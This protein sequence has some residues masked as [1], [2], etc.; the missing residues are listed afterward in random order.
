MRT[1]IRARLMVLMLIPAISLTALSALQFRESLSL[2]TETAQFATLVE[3][4]EAQGSLTHALQIERTRTLE[5]FHLGDDGGMD[6][7]GEDLGAARAATDQAL[8]AFRA[9]ADPGFLADLDPGVA[10]AIA[11][12]TEAVADVQESRAVIDAGN[13]MDGNVRT[14]YAEPI[15]R[16][17]SIDDTVVRIATNPVV[18]TR[19]LAGSSFARLKDAALDR[20]DV[21][22]LAVAGSIDS[23]TTNR[24]V[25]TLAN[26]Q[27]LWL[28]N[29]R[30]LLPESE[31]AAYAEV[32]AVSPSS[33]VARVVGGLANDALGT[34]EEI[35][36]DNRAA[37]EALR[38][39]EQAL[40]AESVRQATAVSDA[41]RQDAIVYGVLALL[42]VLFTVYLLITLARQ[43]TTPMRRLTQM[44]NR[45]A[46]Q[47]PGTVEAVARGEEVDNDVLADSAGA[48]LLNRRDELGDLARALGSAT[49]QASTLALEQARTRQGVARTI[50]DV[51]R[52]E[53]SL[54]ERQLSLLE[55]MEEAEEDPEQLS[56]LFRLD[57][58]ATRMRRNAENLLLLS[59]GQLPGAN[60]TEPQPLVDVIRTAAAET[61]E[62]ARVDVRVGMSL[63][64]VGYAATPISHLLAEL[65]ENATSFSPPTTRVTVTSSRDEG[66]VVVT[67]T[68]RGLGMEAA[69]LEEARHRL[70]APPML[71]AAE[72]RRLGLYVVGLLAKRLGIAVDIQPRAD[73]GLDV[74]VWV[75]AQ[76]FT[77]PLEE[78]TGPA[79]LAAAVQQG[80][81]PSYQDETAPTY[82]TAA[83][84]APANG[85]EAPAN[86][87]FGGGP[88]VFDH[89]SAPVMPEMPAAPTTPTAPATPAAPAAPVAPH[90]ATPSI[91]AAPDALSVMHRLLDANPATP[92]PLPAD[93][94]ASL[95]QLPN[96][97]PALPQ[98][99]AGGEEGRQGGL[100]MASASGGRTVELQ[101]DSMASLVSGLAGLYGDDDAQGPTPA[102]DPVQ[103]S[104]EA[105]SAS[106]VTTPDP[107][108]PV[109]GYGHQPANPEAPATPTPQPVAPPTHLGGSSWSTPF[110]SREEQ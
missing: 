12:A 50:S 64:I 52:R 72:S 51:A 69:D 81:Q 74:R 34:V 57:H 27:D 71:E 22:L 45:V 78:R 39:Q 5:A 1:S 102:A 26:A 60:E 88:A 24:Q 82:P 49:D 7:T 15:T 46:E 54:V 91:D 101:A 84:N 79:G 80:G 95:P 70:T 10:E 41:A 33:E 96:R 42:A 93:V 44:A 85:V 20:G 43:I 110:P 30:R 2:G 18:Q 17:L 98:R 83:P 97:A 47:L 21:V 55:R 29:L 59:A 11:A 63:D 56:Q 90:A 104:P 61:E 75:P 4:A 23:G 19:L 103:H 53:Q 87:L 58:L 13:L 35:A 86:P 77:T 108:A 32:A 92:P 48:H 37:A 28:N 105:P 99:A 62:Y 8:G 36:A 109:E 66:G 40:A 3:I 106:A 14:A 6:M 73:Q 65:I 76:L 67:V 25:S 94:Q 89:E 38:T 31:H 107:A 9:A 68:D 100:S 16:L